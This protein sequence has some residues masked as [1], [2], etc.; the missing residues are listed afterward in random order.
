MSGLG[1]ALA[2]EGS[3]AELAP[4]D[5]PDLL[6]CRVRCPWCRPDS[7]A[8]AWSPLWGGVAGVQGV[9]RGAGIRASSSIPARSVGPR[10]LLLRPLALT[11][12]LRAAFAGLQGGRTGGPERGPAR[13][14]ACGRGC[15]TGSVLGG[16]RTAASA[17]SL[18]GPRLQSP[19]RPSDPALARTRAVA[20]PQACGCAQHLPCWRGRALEPHSAPR[21][22]APGA[23][24]SSAAAVGPVPSPE[25]SQGHRHLRSSSVLSKQTRSALA[26]SAH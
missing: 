11:P 13:L 6:N 18:M 5:G 8:E 16:S 1:Q 2:Q 10:H 26:V 25:I 3:G 23:S 21:S 19:R 22:Q 9:E 7:E 24:G 17:P 15:R 4:G 12:P 14:T 20:D